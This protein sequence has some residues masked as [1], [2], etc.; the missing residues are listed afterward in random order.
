MTISIVFDQLLKPLYWKMFLSSPMYVVIACIKI[1]NLVY[2]DMVRKWNS[3]E[4]LYRKILCK[5]NLNRIINIDIFQ[6][7]N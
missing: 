6:F 1:C 4:I 3:K 7:D 5:R 2:F